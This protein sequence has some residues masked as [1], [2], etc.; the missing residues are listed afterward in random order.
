MKNQSECVR[1]QCRIS[2]ISD[3]MR[4][5]TLILNQSSFTLKMIVKHAVMLPPAGV[6]PCVS[7]S[8]Q[9]SLLEYRK[10]QREARRSGSK[11]EC[12]SPVST[13]P[14]LTVD[15]FPVGMETSSEP[16][17]PTPPCNI[18]VVKEPQPCEEADVQ[19]ERG[20]REGEGQWCV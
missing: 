12:S 20:E 18:T 8:S 14:P 4:D 1:G 5:C 6:T 19:G 2:I 9:V 13:V 15:A 11:T 17:A 10:R 7:A 16:P 3:K